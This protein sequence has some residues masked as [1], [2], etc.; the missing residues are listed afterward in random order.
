V[1]VVSSGNQDI[2]RGIVSKNFVGLIDQDKVYGASGENP[3]KP[4]PKAYIN[5]LSEHNISLENPAQIMVVGDNIEKDLTP[6]IKSGM[7]TVFFNDT[8]KANDTGVK[9]VKSMRDLLGLLV[10]KPKESSLYKNSVLPEEFEVLENRMGGRKKFGVF[11]ANN[12][13]QASISGELGK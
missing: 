12:L 5:P 8:N 11:T 13:Q 6:A 7:D 4:D 9:E 2:V 10:A 3:T 1:F